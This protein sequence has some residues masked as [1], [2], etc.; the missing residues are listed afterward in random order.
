MAFIWQY[1]QFQATSDLYFFLVSV[2]DTN[3]FRAYDELLS[4]R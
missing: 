4:Q 2:T 3:H 1:C